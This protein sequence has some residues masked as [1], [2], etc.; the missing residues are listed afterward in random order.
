MSDVMEADF[1]IKTNLKDVL[2]AVNKTSQE[3]GKLANSFSQVSKQVDDIVKHIENLAAVTAKVRQTVNKTT[4]NSN[5]YKTYSSKRT[6]RVTASQGNEAIA[7][8]DVV[9]TG[10]AGSKSAD[11]KAARQA[12]QTAL[13]KQNQLLD[14]Q[15]AKEKELVRLEK[16]RATL[17][18]EKA[19]NYSKTVEAQSLNAQAKYLNAQTKAAHPELFAQ[20][21]TRRSMKYQTGKALAN[22]GDRASSF[23]IGGR[24]A[25]DILSVL[26]STLKSPAMGFSAALEK[27]TT[28]VLDFSKA[29]ATA[30]AEIEA[31]KTQLGVVFSNQSQ[32]S[33]MFSDIAQYSIKSPFGVQQTSELAILLKQSGVY[34]S[35]LM[36]TLKMLGDTAGGNMEKMKRIANNYAQIVSIGKASMLDMRQFAYAGIPI[37]EAVSNEL[38]VS[39]QRLR[40]LISDGKVTSEIIEKVFKDLTGING[41][42]ENATEK[43]AKTLKARMQNLADARQLGLSAVGEWGVNLGTR[44][45]NDSVANKMV[46]LTENIYQWLYN[47]V[48]T[49]NIAKNVETIA[50]RDTKI[51]DLEE[52]IEYNKKIGNKELAKQLEAVLKQERAK[53]SPEKDRASL[54]ASYQD[55]TARLN[56]LRAGGETRTY[57]EVIQ[58]LAEALT[59]AY[60][61][62]D[63]LRKGSFADMN[64]EQTSEYLKSLGVDEDRLDL[65]Y[66]AIQLEIETLKEIKAAFE[67]AASV[68][69]KEKAAEREEYTFLSQTEMLESTNKLS[70]STKSLNASFQE[71]ASLYEDSEQQKKKR[72]EEHIKEL[73]AA[74][75]ELRK[76]NRYTTDNK[77]TVDITKMGAADF[78]SAANKGAFKAS[79]L[80]LTGGKTEAEQKENRTLFEKRLRWILEEASSNKDLNLSDPAKTRLET[81]IKPL[82]DERRTNK[83]FFSLLL[84][85]FKEIDKTI[86][87]GVDEAVKSLDKSADSYEKDKANLNLFKHLANAAALNFNIQNGGVNA[88][89]NLAA[90]GG[91]VTTPLWKRV[92]SQYTGLSASAIKNTP[93][94]IQAYH[95]DVSARN[96]ASGVFYEMFKN[97]D[98]KSIQKML[99]TT[100]GTDKDDTFLLDWSKVRDNLEK[101]ALSLSASTR[102]IDAYKQGL[103]AELETY[104]K[105]SSEGLTAMESDTS[106]RRV[107]KANTFAKYLQDFKD[108]LINPFGEELIATTKEG[109][110]VKVTAKEKENGEVEFYDKN[111]NKIEAENIE[112]GVHLLE[113]IDKHLQET[114]QK[115]Q[116]AAVAQARNQVLS[117]MLSSQ[118]KNVLL[119]YQPYGRSEEARFLMQNPE[120]MQQLFNDSMNAQ[121][122]GTKYTGKSNEDILLAAR[123]G[124]SDA[125]KLIQDV[126][127]AIKEGI[128]KVVDSEEYKKLKADAYTQQSTASAQK[129]IQDLAFSQPWKYEDGVLSPTE[130][131]GARGLRNRMAD[132]WGVGKDFDMDTYNN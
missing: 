17:T 19:K 90:N 57:S 71:L 132:W 47:K 104:A 85:T 42:F 38:G 12:A 15:I 66:E 30:F 10:K 36:N 59:K 127:D 72:E 83:S 111:N 9:Y 28:A 29:A 49:I 6:T 105:L 113:E 82:L 92:L 87:H 7:V 116:E 100:G 96:L 120:Q 79:K 119:S 32:A 33:A 26:G 89:P 1:E 124:E 48:N 107:T 67:K 117:K 68:S 24:L 108:Q 4:N 129:Y 62:G 78:L 74:Q 69:E 64:S 11:A 118:M 121:K 81:L 18:G 102:V 94:T 77:G 131:N 14:E 126:F 101:F 73:K 75:K 39:Q 123:N 98:V 63:I 41:I 3:V 110:T 16:E 51:K 37:F 40:K 34:A 86:E 46:S 21:V 80:D 20:G 43:G 45:G 25:G 95:S 76:L 61:I 84:S 114:K 55:K 2:G 53:S 22:I 13:Q 23:G 97:G 112:V 27:G 54:Y 31:T 52:L 65:Q 103:E 8:G 5:T 106:V 60:A 125:V 93:D 35:D 58:Q 56:E 122:V 91:N 115:V 99:S 88:D 109:K 44:T 70:D 128:T 130:Y 50:N